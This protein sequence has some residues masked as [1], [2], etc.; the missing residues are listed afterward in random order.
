MYRKKVGTI[1]PH[2]T[3]NLLLEGLGKS[4]RR[5]LMPKECIHCG[6]SKGVL[7]LEKKRKWFFFFKGI[8]YKC[9]KCGYIIEEDYKRLRVEREYHGGE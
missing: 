7:C 2:Q 4:L 9:I 8:R 3:L 6:S 5:M 1:N